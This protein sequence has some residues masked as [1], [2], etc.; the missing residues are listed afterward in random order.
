MGWRPTVIYDQFNSGSNCSLDVH[1][2]RLRPHSQYPGGITF[3]TR[4]SN[5][6]DV[7]IGHIGLC[8]DA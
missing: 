6:T 1:C 5:Y 2:R 3:E 4:T 8:A 7:L